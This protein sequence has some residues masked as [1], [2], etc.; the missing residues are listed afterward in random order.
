MRDPK[1]VSLSGLLQGLDLGLDA[2][3]DLVF[4]RTAWRARLAGVLAKGGAAE[5]AALD[6][7]LETLFAPVVSETPAD[8]PAAPG[9]GDARA[10]DAEPRKRK[11]AG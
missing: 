9:E 5:R 2:G 1:S 8:A 7:D 6:I 10:R 11:A 4:V 3:A